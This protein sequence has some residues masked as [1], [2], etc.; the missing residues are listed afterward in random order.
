VIPIDRSNQRK[1]RNLCNAMWAKIPAERRDDYWP[2]YI[3]ERPVLK[4]KARWIHVIEGG[5]HAAE[6]T[7]TNINPAAD[8]LWHPVGPE[9]MRRQPALRRA[10]KQ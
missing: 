2:C 3:C 9:C 5:G 8:M 6:D 1:A 10:A 7:D 4:S